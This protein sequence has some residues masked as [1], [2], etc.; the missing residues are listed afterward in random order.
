[1]PAFLQMLVW[2]IP[3]WIL[4]AALAPVVFAITQRFPLRNEAW[5]R[6]A[7][8]HIVA[9]LTLSIGHRLVYLSICRVLYVEAYRN[10]PTLFDLYRSDLVFNLPTGFMSYA[11]FLLAGTIIE[12]YSKAAQAELEA[13]KA[14]LQPHFLFNTLHSISSLQMT[15]VEA[16]SRMTARLGEFL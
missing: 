9:C 10:I 15:D 1:P 14:Q 8:I 13:L 12:F 7:A 6:N 11:T 4:W 5:L 16:A 2:E 3:Y